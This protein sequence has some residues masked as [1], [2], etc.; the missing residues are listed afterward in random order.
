MAEQ[1]PT[2]EEQLLRLIEKEDDARTPQYRRRRGT[3]LGFGNIKIFI[4]SI[5]KRITQGW[6]KL[7]AGVKEPNLKLLNKVF[8]VISVILL[9]YSI[10]DFVFGRPNLERAYKKAQR[11]QKQEEPEYQVA[12]TARPFL[13][14]LEM[15]RR[16]NIFSPIVLQEEVQPV[17]KKTELKDM[18]KDLSLVG[19][20]MDPEPVAMIENK[21]EKK[22]YF[23]RKGDIIDK[24]TVE[25]ITGTT[26]ILSY[27]GETIELL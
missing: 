16:R 19:I 27:K 3:L 10:M 25:E 11:Y 21:R 2:P 24:F 8:L 1:Q 20:S 4:L 7:K 12:S 18:A 13:H 26:V 14:Y 22:T 15:V 9:T 23:L 5:G 6:Q 17:V